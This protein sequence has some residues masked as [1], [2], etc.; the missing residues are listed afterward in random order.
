[1]HRE[2]FARPTDLSTPDLA[3]RATKLGLDVPAFT[4]CVESDR[5]DSGIV[6]D[7]E[8]GR[9]LGIQGTPTFFVNGMRL[10]GSPTREDLDALILQESSRPRS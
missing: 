4:A 5:H 7:H 1:M 2:L 8:T 9:A 3:S 10:Q 6:G